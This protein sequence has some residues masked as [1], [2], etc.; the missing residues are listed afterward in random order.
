MQVSEPPSGSQSSIVELPQATPPNPT[1]VSPSHAPLEPQVS[2]RDTGLFVDGTCRQASAVSTVHSWSSACKGMS[3]CRCNP[4][5]PSSQI[6]IAGEVSPIVDRLIADR[7][8]ID[9]LTVDRLIVGKLSHTSVPPSMLISC[10][11]YTAYKR[12]VHL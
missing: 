9:K 4:Y 10:Q 1:A 8:I 7:L 5:E 2:T 12:R 3:A 11:R 6:L